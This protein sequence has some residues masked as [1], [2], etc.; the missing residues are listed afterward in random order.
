MVNLSEKIKSKFSIGKTEY[1][2]PIWLAS[3]TCGYGEELSELLDL[4]LLGGVVLKGTTIDP[5]AGNDLPRIA[6][7]PS[8][9][10]NCIGLQNPGVNVVI[11]K[12]LPFLKNYK[13]PLILNIAGSTL[14]EYA[15]IT[16]ILS[17]KTKLSAIEVNISC[18]NVKQGGLSFGT[19]PKIAEKVIKT[20]KKESAFPVI[21][22]LSPNVTSITDIAKAV[23]AGGA[24]AISLINTL[25]GMAFDLETQKPKLSNIMGGLS[26]PAIKP[27]AIRMVYE[28]SKITKLPIIGIGGISSLNDVFEFFL[29]GATAVQIGS[30]TLT[31]LEEVKKIISYANA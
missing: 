16:K 11:K 15:Q 8:G 5:K 18:P 2:N 17:E 14:E 12:K 6:E 24:D 7:T 29:A 25:L 21:A 13:V 3:G 30:L 10:L 4:N 1:P 31:N 20:V 28:V 27:I 23:E 19:D 26:G 9:I 22:K